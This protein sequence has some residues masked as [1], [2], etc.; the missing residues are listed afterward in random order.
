MASP[1]VKKTNIAEFLVQAETIPVIDVRSPSEFNKGH[2]PGA[3]N[4]PLFDDKQREAV[5]I[6]YK[7]E[8]RQK[9]VIKG[10]NLIGPNIGLKLENAIEATRDNKLILYC[11]R[12]GM[13]SEAMAWLFTQGNIQTSVLEGGYKS[14]RRFILDK[15][16]EPRKTIVLGGLTGSSKT[17]ILNHIKALGHQVVDLE[18]LACH[19]GSAFGSLGQKEQPSSEHFANKLFSEYSKTNPSLP[20]WLEDESHNIGTVFMPVSFYK[21]LAE[22]PAIILLIEKELRM[23][24]LIEEYSQYPPEHL[25]ESV[26]KISKRLGGDNTRN[27]LKAIDE[28]DFTRA[29]EITLDY[30]D[31]AYMYGIKQKSSDKIIFL[32]TDTNDIATNAERVLE[33]AKK[34][35]PETKI[36]TAY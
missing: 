11:W 36:I 6:S 19:K 8:G 32:K 10:L 22:S 20:V 17:C 27:A 9:A 26:M 2:I 30:Y 25:K 4:I 3:L 21:N 1:V 35:I 29:I 14:Y 34:I 18:K 16:S 15:L 12:G 24:R 28:G 23:P 13:R 5:G 31:K 33:A 7:Q